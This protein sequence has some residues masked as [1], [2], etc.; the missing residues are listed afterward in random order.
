VCLLSLQECS[1]FEA[2]RKPSL[3]TYQ[4]LNNQHLGPIGS[5]ECRGKDMRPPLR[6]AHQIRREK[7]STV[8]HSECVQPNCILR[9]TPNLQ[10]DNDLIYW[11][12]ACTELIFSKMTREQIAPTLVVWQCCFVDDHSCGV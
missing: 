12:F 10:Q 8:S 6:D 5:L 3:S 11:F 7:K 9:V 4:H 1:C 2:K